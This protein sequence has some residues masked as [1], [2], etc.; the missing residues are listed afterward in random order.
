MPW[1]AGT[2]RSDGAS[3]AG[4]EEMR[5]GEKDGWTGKKAGAKDAKRK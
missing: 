4:R 1:Q 2:R 3:E 5:M